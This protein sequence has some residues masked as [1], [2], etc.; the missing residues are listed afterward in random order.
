MGDDEMMNFK[1][2]NPSFFPKHAGNVSLKDLE[3]AGAV[4]SPVNVP[5]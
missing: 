3:E 1:K 2:M 5:W 4:C